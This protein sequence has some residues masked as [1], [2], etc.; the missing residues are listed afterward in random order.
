M[1]EFETLLEGCRNALERFVNYKLRNRADAEDI[2]QEI[3]LTASQ[4]FYTLKDKSVFKAWIL[5]IARN[6]CT[7]YFRAKARAMEISLDAIS[8]NKLSYGRMG[9]TE[10]NTVSETFDRLGDKDKQILYLFFFREMPQRDIAQC[11]G[12]PVGTVK[13]RL[14]TAKENFRE[15]YPYSPKTKGES[16]M[17]K[18]PQYL[19][20][21]T[22][23]KSDSAPFSVTFEELSNW[24]IIPKTGE[25]ITWASYDLPS[26]EKAEEV[27]SAVTGKIILHELEG[28][29]IKS[30]FTNRSCNNKEHFYMAQ[31]TDTHCRWLGERYFDKDGVQRYLTF[32]DGDAFLNEWG[33]GEDNC[34]VE[35]QLRKKGQIECNAGGYSVPD[36][37]HC[38][39][40]VGSYSVT[41]GDR[42]YQTILAS[43]YYP[44]GAFTEQY[45]DK[46]GRTVLWR[47]FNRD[48]R[49]WKYNEGKK[50]SEILPDNEH[51]AVS[52]EIYVHWYDCIT[53]YI[54]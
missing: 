39:D 31:L 2:F 21:Y 47:R 4:K 42:L 12:I 51:I 1:D 32:L 48:D 44:N 27:F 29:E 33:F 35:T 50:W 45:I 28:V 22:I 6:K 46:N 8:E 14:H 25:K 37:K 9:V 49:R 11:L 52:G 13:S 30:V 3:C 24:F 40:V 19:P 5:S 23:E 41:M 18:L 7:D 54:L 16:T 43:E 20:A 38:F 34:G 36:K 10:T 26:R 15:I 17:K 53:D